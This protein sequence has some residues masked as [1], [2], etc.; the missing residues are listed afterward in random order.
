MMMIAY[1]LGLLA[2]VMI[3]VPMVG[4]RHLR[5]YFVGASKSELKGIRR[6]FLATALALLALNHIVVLDTNH[7][8]DRE[9]IMKSRDLSG[10]INLVNYLKDQLD[11]INANREKLAEVNEH[12]ASSLAG[13]PEVQ[14]V[15]Q[16]YLEADQEEMQVLDSRFATLASWIDGW[17]S[18]L[19][20]AATVP[21]LDDRA[22]YQ[23]KAIQDKQEF[24]RKMAV[25]CNE[26]FEFAIASLRAG[27][28]EQATQLGEKLISTYNGLPRTL[29][30]NQV[31]LGSFSLGDRPSSF[32]YLS[33]RKGTSEYDPNCLCITC[34]ET[35]SQLTADTFEYATPEEAQLLARSGKIRYSL[36]I[37][38]NPDKI[39]AT[40]QVPGEAAVNES[41][42]QADYGRGVN[43]AL[44]RLFA[45]QVVKNNSTRTGG[46]N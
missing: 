8:R 43:A 4:D 36:T 17:Q 31:A 32:F 21:D 16:K 12:L 45:T 2:A 28:A 35:G 25:Q 44:S 13:Y 42:P 41:F 38:P 1:T 22:P 24:E 5:S 18:K 29:Q 39:I 30:T 20:A 26:V 6:R 19:V 40:F 15:A 7:R 23:F 11:E 10:Q 33:L 37:R 14:P 34:L 46:W 9:L 3:F 27:L